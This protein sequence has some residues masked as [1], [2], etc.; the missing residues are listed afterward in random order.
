MRW[1]QAR[2]MPSEPSVGAA[3]LLWELYVRAHRQRRRVPHRLVRGQLRGQHHNHWLQQLEDLDTIYGFN[4]E[5]CLR[6]RTGGV[7]LFSLASMQHF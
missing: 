1:L 2:V 6:K 4:R 3:G 7:D 5:S